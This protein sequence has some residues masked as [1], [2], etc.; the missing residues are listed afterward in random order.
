MSE[1]TEAEGKS[2]NRCRW[3]VWWPAVQKAV[4]PTSIRETLA[5]SVD[6]LTFHS[7][8]DHRFK[9]VL[10]PAL[11]F[12]NWVLQFAWREQFFH[13]FPVCVAT[14]PGEHFISTASTTAFR[15]FELW[16]LCENEQVSLHILVHRNL[17]QHNDFIHY[18][19][20]VTLHKITR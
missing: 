3:E 16:L 15:K 10:I 17:V 12:Q 14:D 4:G 20:Q 2:M 19:Y 6:I 9:L 13:L 1:V 5:P 11:P 18:L 8:W 7:V